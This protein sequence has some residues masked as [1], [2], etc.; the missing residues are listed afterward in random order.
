MRVAVTG[1]H[2]GLG[3][4]LVRRLQRH[5][6]AAFA[7]DDLPV[8][9]PAAVRDRLTAARP[10]VIFHLAAMTSVDGCELD[11]DGAFAVNSLGSRNVAVASRDVGAVVVAMST[12][13][14]FDGT[15]GDPYHEFDEPRPRSVYGRSKLAGEEEVR[16]HAPE[17]LV[18]RTAWVF[19]AG[20]DFLTRSVRALAAGAEVGGIVDQVGSPTFVDHLAERLPQ[21]VEAGARGLVHVA[22]PEPVTWYDVLERAREIGAL[23]GTLS[24][25]KMGDL[26]RPAPRPANSALTS[27]VLPAH[28]VPPLP[29]LDDAIREVIRRAHA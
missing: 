23:P 2:G 17:H 3:R 18:V 28:G 26:D 20:D 1:A 25:Q 22:G 9:D 15:K 14:V 12:D 13:Y 19:G 27:L 6:V 21:L 8:E 11:P 29:L 10:E 5:D 7:H 16:E 4:A 24:E